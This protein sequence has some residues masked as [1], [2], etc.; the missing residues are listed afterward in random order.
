MIA[1]KLC[2]EFNT[3]NW[4]YNWGHWCKRISLITIWETTLS[5]Q[6]R[7][8]QQREREREK[9]SSMVEGDKNVE[10]K[11]KRRREHHQGRE[12]RET[13]LKKNK[14]EREIRV[15]SLLTDN[16]NLINS[17]TFKVFINII[18]HSSLPSA[19]SKL[20]YPTLPFP[21]VKLSLPNKNKFLPS[22]PLPPNQT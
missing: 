12:E 19:H 17:D 9:R 10:K 20:G 22:P 4:K 7:R 13:E 15:I 3:N 11:K 21:S 8:T 5:G 16:P 2:Y 14:V 1:S 18:I 6:C